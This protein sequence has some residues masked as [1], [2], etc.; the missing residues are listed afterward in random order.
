[1]KDQLWMHNN[2][3]RQL[4]SS[5]VMQYMHYVYRNALIFSS[6]FIK[7]KLEHRT[8]GLLHG[9]DVYAR[10]SMFHFNVIINASILMSRPANAM[11]Y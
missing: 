1:M 11:V 5:N 10:V 3:R 8:I 7:Q 6:V 4:P 9:M 2:E